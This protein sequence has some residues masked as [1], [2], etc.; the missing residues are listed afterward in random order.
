MTVSCSR[1]H[2]TLTL[3]KCRTGPPTC[4]PPATGLW[5]STKQEWTPL[6]LKATVKQKS[7]L[8][9]MRLITCM[10][11]T[12]GNFHAQ[13]SCQLWSSVK[14]HVLLQP[15]TELTALNALWIKALWRQGRRLSCPEDMQL[16]CV[17]VLG[18]QSQGSNRDAFSA[19]S[20]PW[21]IAC[22]MCLA[23]IQLLL[24]AP[25]HVQAQT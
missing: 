5:I 3:I 8:W 10:H 22:E 19:R 7:S 4:Q 9:F 14:H 20:W 21:Q 15:R 1:C 12:H 16:K 18:W 2:H 11:Q 25:P 17:F 6:K 23:D 24:P 13:T